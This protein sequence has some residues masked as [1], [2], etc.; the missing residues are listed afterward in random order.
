MAFFKK[1]WI[2]AKGCYYLFA[3]KNIQKKTGGF[4]PTKAL[5]SYMECCF[6]EDA[7]K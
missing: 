4:K 6:L 5:K 7:S 1:K 3:N 2:T